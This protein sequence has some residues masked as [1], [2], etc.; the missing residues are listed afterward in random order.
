MSSRK[1]D[2][3][4]HYRDVM[5]DKTNVIFTAIIVTYGSWET[6]KIFLSDPII[7]VRAHTSA[8]NTPPH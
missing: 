2:I 5:F 6:E 1:T 7:H 4:S 8:Q 3:L